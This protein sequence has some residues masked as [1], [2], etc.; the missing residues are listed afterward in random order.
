MI[1]SC[2]GRSRIIIVTSLTSMRLARA[3][4]RMLVSIEAV[5]SIAGAASRPVTSFSM[6]T[7]GPGLNIDPRSETATTESA[8]ASPRDTRRVPSMG[9]TATSTI[10]GSPVPISSPLKSIGARSFSPSPITTT[11]SICTVL[12]KRR[13]ASTAAWSAAFL[14]PLP[15]QRAAAKAAASVVRTRSRDRL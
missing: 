1:S 3:M 14:S 5:M 15:T 7:H 12:K 8:F 11:P 13:M 9:S 2:R 6:Y 10:G 4:F